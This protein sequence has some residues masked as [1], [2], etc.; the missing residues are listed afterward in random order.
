[1]HKQMNPPRPQ[2]QIFAV[3]ES[4]VEFLRTIC[5]LTPVADFLTFC[6]ALSGGELGDLVGALHDFD[7]FVEVAKRS[8]LTAVKRHHTELVEASDESLSAYI[9][10]QLQEK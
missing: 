6:T 3:V 8:F 10:H 2:M 7:G 4:K 5:H 1:M 9:E